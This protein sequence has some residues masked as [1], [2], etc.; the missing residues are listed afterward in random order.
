M[1]ALYIQKTTNV[2]C[3]ILGDLLQLARTLGEVVKGKTFVKV[4]RDNCTGW[5]THVDKHGCKELIS[6]VSSVNVLESSQVSCV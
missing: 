3:L 1:F 2:V 5:E 6:G 4:K